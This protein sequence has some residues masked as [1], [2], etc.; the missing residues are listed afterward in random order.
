MAPWSH[1]PARWSGPPCGFQR[2]VSRRSRKVGLLSWVAVGG[3]CLLASACVPGEGGDRP[4]PPCS[5]AASSDANLARFDTARFLNPGLEYAPGLRW[6]WPGG[7]V[8]EETLRDQ[9]DLFA[10][11]GYGMVE[12]QPTTFGLRADELERDPR[13]RTVGTEPFFDR[14][15]ALSQMLRERGMSYDLTLGSGWPNGGLAVPA[16]ATEQQVLWAR[17]DVRGPATVDIPLARPGEP[18]WV[19]L[20]N[21]VGPL[22]LTFDEDLQLEAVVATPV[23][24]AAARPPVL[25]Q[26]VDLTGQVAQ[27]R[28][29]F[30]APAGEHAVLAIYRNR[31]ER[32][33]AATALAGDPEQTRVIDHLGEAGA[34]FLISHQVS[35]WLDALGDARPAHFFVDSLELVGELPWSPG[36]EERYRRRVGHSPWLDMPF[37][38]R[39]GGESKYA[40]SLLL[41]AAAPA[42]A[43]L[44]PERGQR[45][46]EDYEIVRAEAFAEDY[47]APLLS[48]LHARGV[49]LRLQ[50]HGGWGNLLDD[51]ARVDVAE[52]ESFF[53]GGRY[54]FLAL[55]ASAAHVAGRRMVSQ[56][57]FVTLNLAG[58]TALGEEDL[59]AL[60]GLAYTAG[61]NRPVH[62]VCAYP[63]PR[64]EGDA[65]VPFQP[66][67]KASFSSPFPF[68]AQIEPAAPRWSFLGRFNR[69]QARIGYALS[70]G[71]PRVDLAWLTT[72][73][74][75]SDD[76]VISLGP[77]R[78]HAEESPQSRALR[79]AGYTY[80]R[81]SPR[82]LTSARAEGGGVVIGAQR[83]RGVL[84]EAARVLAP[85]LLARLERLAE[86]GVPIVWAGAAPERAPG[87]AD[88]QAR[89]SRV[90]EIWSRLQGRV[91]RVD[92]IADSLAALRAMNLLA[93]VEAVS[94]L[95]P[96]G[97]QQREVDSGRL[98]WLFNESYFPQ[99]FLVTLRMQAA[100]AVWL[101]PETGLAEPVPLRPAADGSRVS[102]AL[103]AMRG[104]LLLLTSNDPVVIGR[105]REQCR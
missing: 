103:K 93:E 51:Y 75:A 60:V 57:S 92:D 11:S 19:G 23:L 2:P 35:P 34:R 16:D 56:E 83:Y 30:F 10:D 63:F 32:L 95:G 48:G 41:S 85:A 54:D 79:Q 99:E 78:L 26:P 20:T 104:G 80:D 5:T 33:V 100:E 17:T 98:I 27:G 76:M 44:D 25:G 9:V 22:I 45:V 66:D 94:L 88:A 14:L 12:V 39:E 77:L 62:S 4:A 21:L 7:A 43:S 36:L 96:I 97:I 31:T 105:Q 68:T 71:Q 38:F 1:S 37:L 28:L 3:L 52:S 65:W 49:K 58:P 18:G 40:D 91:Q 70:R 69:I 6:L 55:A 47:L 61:I 59:F 90:A 13:I 50:A 8:D 67:S 72:A 89:D 53:G 24:D 101:D 82:A 42:F 73:R 15:R 87:A 81:V 46:R 29:R 102:L 74:T 64:P 84:V 86:Q